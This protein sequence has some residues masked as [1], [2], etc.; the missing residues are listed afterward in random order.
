MLRG[1]REENMPNWIVAFSHLLNGREDLWPVRGSRLLEQTSDARRRAVIVDWFDGFEGRRT[2]MITGYKEAGDSLVVLSLA[3]DWHRGHV[4]IYPVLFCYRQF[5]ELSLKAQ[6]EDFGGHAKVSIAHSGHNLR[7]L[8]KKFR[9][10][11][12]VL[13]Y[14]FPEEMLVAASKNILEFDKV[15]PHSFAFRYATKKSG[16]HYTIEFSMV[17]IVTLRDGMNALGNFFRTSSADLATR[18]RKDY[19][20]WANH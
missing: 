17:D 11:L 19:P 8:L 2:N 18:Y 10:M 5:I 14:N 4:L 3:E 9:T 20:D 15:D 6:I 1:I 16:E 7:T 13:K 12:Q